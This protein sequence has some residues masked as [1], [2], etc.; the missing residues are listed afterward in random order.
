ME[1]INT[2]SSGD[3]KKVL[4]RFAIPY[5][6][7]AFLQTLYGLVDLFVVGMYNTAATTTAVS[8]GSQ[9]MHMLTVIIL[10]LI[11]GI[12][13]QVGNNLGAENFKAIRKAIGTSIMFFSIVAVVFA[14]VM[15]LFTSLIVKIVMTPAEAVTETEQYLRICS[16]GIPLIFAFNIISGIL[17]GLGDSKRPM[18]AVAAACVVNIVLDFVFV[19]GLNMGARGA[20]YAT[21]I[22]QLASVIAAYFL[23]KT[24]YSDY[25]IKR[26]ELRI[27]RGLLRKIIYVGIPVALQDGFIQI[28]FMVITAI[29]NSRGLIDSAAV[30]VVEKLICFF[31]LVPSAYMSAISAITA[32]NLG[33]SKPQRA[34]D[35]LKYGLMI[36]VGWGL[37][38]AIICQFIP[39][40]FVGL[41]TKEELVR[42][43]GAVYLRAYSV[44]TAFA[45]I[46]FC[47]S[48]YFCGAEKSYVS[49]LHNLISVLFIR[50][51]GSYFASI[52]FKDT[53][54]PMG[55]AA[56]AG[57]L[58]SAVICVI[59]YLY[60]NS[61]GDFNQSKIDED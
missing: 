7:A 37:I 19:G 10:G 60:F 42:N 16:I 49:F 34:K 38:I 9:V 11:L 46:H 21:V 35:S 48:G 51:P 56:P 27:D 59:F 36:T 55:C 44:D 33:A 2:L 31:F 54:F 13:V 26:D 18:Y 50:I 1:D 4:V 41:F 15:V 52:M 25:I 8:V 6:V 20:A 39:Q 12:T 22:G 17:R 28:A 32:Q 3:V 57:S 29:A 47:F 43:A 40:V 45:A 14:I 58:V 5:M 24:N 23:Y 61:K 53:L 30:G